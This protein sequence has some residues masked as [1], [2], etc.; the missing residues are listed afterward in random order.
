MSSNSKVKVSRVIKKKM[1]AVEVASASTAGVA[2]AAGVASTAGVAS[3]AEAAS[4]LAKV[5]ECD[6][7]YESYN[8]S[9]HLPVECEYVGCKYTICI[10]CVRA[11]LLTS[12]NE[13]HCMHCKQ[14]WTDKFTL[15]LKKNWLADTYRTHQEKLL[16]EIELSKI[17][18]TMEAAERTKALNHELNLRRELTKKMDDL[19]I[20][21]SLLRG[22]YNDSA[23]RTRHITNPTLYNAPGGGGGA[24]L[25]AVEKKVFFMRCTTTD[26]NGML[27]SQ[28]KCGICD[29]YTC[30]DCHAHIGVFANKEIHVCDANDLASTQAIKK[31]T[32]QCPGCHNPI[33][34][35]EG[36]SQMWCT[37]CHTA[38]DWNTGRKVENERLHNP[39]WVE[40][41]RRLGLNPRAPGDVPCGGLCDRVDL[42]AITR[43]LLTNTRVKSEMIQDIDREL[44]FMHEC[45]R[46]INYNTIRE[47]RTANQRYQD[48]EAQRV[49]YIL[50]LMT[51]GD[52]ASYIFRKKR[53]V[54]K[55]T[56]ILHVY[57]LLGA[58]GIDVFNRIIL[59][60]PRGTSEDFTALVVNEMAEF[61]ALREHCNGLFSRISAT[62][63]L[64]VP[65]I[66]PKWSVRTQKYTSKSMMK[67]GGGTPL[68]ETP[69]NPPL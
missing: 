40:H 65:Q 23:T 48:F 67:E 34:R 59:A 38:F 30:A 10:E 43:K 57:E 7:C 11:Y 22:E 20:Q 2:S 33:Y 6:V 39:H 9:T 27:S 68:G 18:Q 13:P 47:L 51:K 45:L 66:G 8:R 55:N 56:E 4:A 17:P 42:R 14:A 15:I 62:Y 5:K 31:E 58:V 53:D 29:E 49:N 1:E 37:G 46:E 35:I 44:M 28:Y 19:R 32:K 64:S 61:N 41:Q 50:G 16:V 54:K 3:S 60:A 24:A 36:C 25:P 12:V 63:S 26:C 52:L 21:I 69:P